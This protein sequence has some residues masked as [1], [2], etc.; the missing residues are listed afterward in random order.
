LG[1]QGT[2]TVQRSVNTVCPKSIRPSPD[3][4]DG[5]RIA[6]V[7]IAHTFKATVYTNVVG[8]IEEV[9]DRSAVKRTLDSMYTEC[10]RKVP[11]RNGLGITYVDTAEVAVT[12]AGNTN[13]LGAFEE[14]GDRP[15]PQGCIDTVYTKVRAPSPFGDWVRSHEVLL[16]GVDG[17]VASYSYIFGPFEEISLGSAGECHVDAI[18]AESTRPLPVGGGLRGIVACI[19]RAWANIVTAGADVFIA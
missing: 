12:G 17:P 7:H 16:T 14:I 9:A 1:N 8:S 2:A 15:T 11:I 5:L 3:I 13:V 4:L 18:R 10:P 6:S 19:D